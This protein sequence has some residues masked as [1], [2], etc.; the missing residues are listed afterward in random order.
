MKTA[1]TIPIYKLKGS[2]LD[3]G[4]YRPISLL[5]NINK[6]LEKLMYNRVYQFLDEKKCFYKLQFG[7]RNKHS[8][9]HAL[10]SITEQIRTALDSGNFACGIFIDF[11]K[12]FDTVNHSILI[13]KLAHYGIRGVGNNWF[14]SY[15]TD[16]SQF[17]SIQGFDSD[18]LPMHH[19][20]PQGSVL[21]PLL[22]LIYI[23]DLHNAI[24]HSHVYHFADDTNLLNISSSPKKIQKQ[25]N[26]DLKNVY[27]WLLANKISLNESKTELIL[28]HKP[29]QAINFNFKI[30]I[31]GYRIQPSD[32]IKY[33][34]MYLDS[35]L[36]GKE[37]SKILST[38]LK[39]S[40]GLLSKIRHYVP[41][42]E[43]KSIYHAIFSSHM[44]YGCQ[45]WGQ[46]M[47]EHTENIS[48]LQDQ[49]LRIINF[50]GFHEDPTPLYQTDKILR[51]KDTVKLNNCL[52]I[53]D[54]LH[55]TLP[56]SFENYFFTSNDIHPLISTRN[57][58]L[59]CIFLPSCNSTTYGLNSIT[60]KS[61]HTWND[62]TVSTKTNLAKLSRHKLK[63]TLTNYFLGN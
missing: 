56:K 29:G 17:V 14:R 24:Q 19:G 54:Y 42:H 20:V 2:K 58:K 13:E 10:I 27:K 34:G 16:R 8:T 48:K 60:V 53:H 1:K 18:L 28:F 36:S 26:I 33:L 59:G 46:T 5:S 4:N 52:L 62:I 25:M 55:D 61:I 50:K 31:N 38:K 41:P 49:A 6:I 12:A 51:L 47:T 7:F 32:Y 44:I 40:N 15:L 11:Q 9:A 23:N 3:T 39:R 43:L 45:I 63:E 37:H 57:S 22:F 35:T 30:K 21:G